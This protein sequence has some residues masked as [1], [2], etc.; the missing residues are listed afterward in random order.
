MD[1]FPKHRRL[2]GYQ[3]AADFLGIKVTTLYTHVFKK[4]VPHIRLNSRSVRFDL[5]ELDRWLEA[6]KVQPKEEAEND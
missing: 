3:A 1:E 2:V 5:D 6:R 4:S